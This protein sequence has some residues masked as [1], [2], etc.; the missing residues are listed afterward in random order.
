MAKAGC[1]DYPLYRLNNQRL[2]ARGSPAG[3]ALLPIPPKGTTC[4]TVEGH[5]RFH[6]TENRT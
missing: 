5:E 6:P 3:P 2:Y 1:I 4:V